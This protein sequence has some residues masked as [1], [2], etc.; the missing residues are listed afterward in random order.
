VFVFHANDDSNVNVSE[1]RDFVQRLKTAGKQVEFMTVP[2]GDHYDSMV[3][4]GIPA[5]IDWLKRA[6]NSQ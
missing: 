4:E 6:A 5:A 2:S 1:S 3:Q